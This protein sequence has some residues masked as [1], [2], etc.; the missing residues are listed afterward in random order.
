MGI[1]MRPLQFIRK[2]FPWFVRNYNRLE[3]RG[4][5]NLPKKGSAIIA[6]N[7]GGGLDWDNFCL[8]SALE[9]FKTNNP[10]RKRI[11][12]LYWDVWSVDHP[13][14]APWVQQFSPIPVNLEGK[15][16]RW[17]IAD[18][19]VK[20]G[21]LIAIMPEGHS[22][23]IK[24]GYRLWKFYPGVIRLHLRYEVPIIPTAIIGCI[25][26]APMWGYDYNP[27]HIPPWENE[28]ILPIILP[29]K[30]IIH[31]GKPMNFEEYYNKKLDTN[32]MFELAKIVRKKVRETISIYLRGTSWKKPYG[33]KIKASF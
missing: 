13:F 4:I 28:R 11:W 22:A 5:N 2:I 19:V 15:G 31:F 18:K 12:L 10:T 17:D 23:T 20:K 24:E 30:I 32:K 16:I 8:M 33:Q 29:R 14:W 27:K 3:V 7:H 6:A 9:R 21:E 1:F 25:E 26:S